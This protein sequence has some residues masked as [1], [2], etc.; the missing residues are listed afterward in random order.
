[1]NL[2]LNKKN[3]K[4]SI[5]NVIL[6]NKNNLKPN[7]ASV[8]LSEYKNIAFGSFK[9]KILDSNGNY[10]TDWNSNGIYEGVEIDVKDIDFEIQNF[11]ND[12]DYYAVFMIKDTNNKT[13]YSKLIKMN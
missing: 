5:N 6:N 10:K 13:Y 1:M 9:Y 3:N 4:I 12:Y 7:I 8:N 11:E 2:I